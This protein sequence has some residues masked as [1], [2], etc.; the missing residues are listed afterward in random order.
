MLILVFLLSVRRQGL[1][2]RAM[3]S[4]GGWRAVKG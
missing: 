4:G 2:Q 1:L 3:G